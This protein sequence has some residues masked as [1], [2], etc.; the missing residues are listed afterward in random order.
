MLDMVTP[1]QHEAPAVINRSRVDN[2]KP[3]LSPAGHPL[4]EAR[5]EQSAD[6]PEA[7]RHHSEDNKER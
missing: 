4:R 7:F 6:Q 3:R 2:A 1:D 5:A